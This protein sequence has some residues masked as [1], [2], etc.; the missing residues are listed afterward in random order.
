MIEHKWWVGFYGKF[1]RDCLSMQGV[2]QMKSESV[3]V[4]EAVKTPL[5][6]FVLVV[7]LVEMIFAVAAGKFYDQRTIIISSML[8]LIFMLVLIVA[9]LA[10]YRPEALNGRR[11]IEDPEIA[12]MRQNFREIE[13]VADMLV[14]DWEFVSQHTPAGEKHAVEA[15]GFSKITKGKYGVSMHGQCIDLAGKPCHAFAI[16]QVFISE[17]GLTYIFEVPQNLGK[18]ILGVGQVNF[19]PVEGKSVVNQMRGN[20]AVLGSEISGKAEF[21]RKNH[22]D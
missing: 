10:C 18:T 20:W 16:K 11:Y 6:F 17:D 12:Q 3:N 5:G 13:Q 21:H 2:L 1:L 7:L 14:G 4:I 22:P 8:A 19:D 15:R 9:A